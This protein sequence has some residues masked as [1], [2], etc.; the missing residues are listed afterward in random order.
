MCILL[1]FLLIAAAGYFKPIQIGDLINSYTDG[2]LP[3][4][5]ICHVY[6]SGLSYKELEVTGGDSIKQMVALLEN[7]K[8]K[9]LLNAPDSWRPESKNTYRLY[10]RNGSNEIQTINILNGRYIDINNNI[11]KI[12]GK[13]D[14][15]KLYEIIILDQ[16]KG[17]MDDFYYDLIDK[18]K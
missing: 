1:I 10:F 3:D 8:V 13:P 4:R 11:Y 14:I 12:T 5:I 18:D 17:E 9:R 16:P 7:M 6:I 15:S 2:V